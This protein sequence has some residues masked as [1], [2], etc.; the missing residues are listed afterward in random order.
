M[1][2]SED[3]LKNRLV[4]GGGLTKIVREAPKQGQR[5]RKINRL[6]I[7]EHE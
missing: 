2:K 5:Q 4:T 1:T 3:R 6:Q 7:N